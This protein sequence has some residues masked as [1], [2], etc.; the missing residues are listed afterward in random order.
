MG[1]IATPCEDATA[2]MAAFK[3]DTLDGDGRVRKPDSELKRG[4]VR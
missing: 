4:D 3:P 2:V 1:A